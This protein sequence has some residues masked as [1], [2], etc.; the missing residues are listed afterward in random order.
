MKANLYNAGL[1]FET[2]NVGEWLPFR[3]QK[4]MPLLISLL[5]TPF[6]LLIGISDFGP[7]GPQIYVGYLL[8]PYSTL[9]F[10]MGVFRTTLFVY[11]AF[12]V[13]VIQFPVYGYIFSVVGKVRTAILT[14]VV[15][16]VLAIIALSIFVLFLKLF[17]TLLPPFP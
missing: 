16:H 10:F 11:L 17:V 6:T 5:V 3:F 15:P 1:M 9:L 8:F 14:V 12:V 7:E 4:W 13:M 2:Q